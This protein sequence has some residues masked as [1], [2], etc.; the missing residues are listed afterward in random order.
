MSETDFLSGGSLIKPCS[1]AVKQVQLIY[2][3]MVSQ[4]GCRG[5]GGCRTVHLLP[6]KRMLRGS[7]GGMLWAESRVDEVRE[8][9]AAV[10]PASLGDRQ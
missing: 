6:E 1:D 5:G 4:R 9:H 3:L 7:G 8:G 2:Q 10:G